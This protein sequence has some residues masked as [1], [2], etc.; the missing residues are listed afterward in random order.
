VN[1]SSTW[2]GLAFNFVASDGRIGSTSPIPMKEITQANATAHTA[3]GCLNG[4]AGRV[5]GSAMCSV[6][7]WPRTPQ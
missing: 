5:A 3:L 2:E 7:I 6:L 4:L 1:S